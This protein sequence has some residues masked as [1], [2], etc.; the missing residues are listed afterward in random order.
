MVEE[1]VKEL[2]WPMEPPSLSMSSMSLHYTMGESPHVAIFID[3][4]RT[5]DMQRCSMLQHNN[6]VVVKV[7]CSDAVR[8][9]RRSRV[10]VEESRMMSDARD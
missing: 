8:W 9:T 6:I 1:Y 4:G 10:E 3:N 2:C 7:M 5:T